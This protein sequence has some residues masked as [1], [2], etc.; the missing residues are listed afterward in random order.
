MEEDSLVK[1]SVAELAGR[2]KGHALPMPTAV[3]GKP[4]VTS[5]HP[6]KVKPKNSPLIEKL[7]A[8]LALSPTALLPSPKSPGVKLQPSPPFSLSPPCSPLSAP[9]R[10]PQR[11]LSVEEAPASFEKP[12]EGGVLPSINKSRARGSVKRRPPTRQHRKSCG[13]EGG[14]GGGST[15]SPEPECQK[16]NGDEEDVFEEGAK[17]AVESQE[18]SSPSPG[19][20]DT[21]HGKDS[22]GK[23]VE[24]DART[25]DEAGKDGT[26][27]AEKAAVAKEEAREPGEEV[28]GESQASGG[29]AEALKE[30]EGQIEARTDP[31]GAAD[32]NQEEEP[33]TETMEAQ[34]GEKEKSTEEEKQEKSGI[35]AD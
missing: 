1:P 20:G 15:P 7:Q 5:P 3:E 25:P 17:D 21:I 11:Q 32:S 30:P 13:D 28:P 31:D 33:K 14:A 18:T 27:D 34:E 26:R 2:F 19:A 4:A 8:N 6:P 29:P 12:A 9:L 22:L 24:A 35:T 10:P 16:Q 23:L